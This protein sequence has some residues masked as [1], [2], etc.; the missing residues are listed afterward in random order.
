MI[1]LM[2]GAFDP[3][4]LGHL[5]VI[6][7]LLAHGHRLHIGVDPASALKHNHAPAETRREMLEA[8]LDHA[9]S[10][11]EKSRVRVVWAEPRA[12]DWITN[13]RAAEGLSR[14]EVLYVI[15][16]DQVEQLDRWFRFPEILQECTWAY[17]LRE[18]HAITQNSRA[19][20]TQLKALPEVRARACAST[21]IRRILA[22]RD[23]TPDEITATTGQAVWSILKEHHLY[24]T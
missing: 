19:W 20:S 14:T 22:R 17:W 13:T 4:H 21:E 2:G 8:M 11:E 16:A 12:W 23:L 24:G 5:D 18:G 6:Q 9:L 3:P 1:T 15:G 10:A 7:G